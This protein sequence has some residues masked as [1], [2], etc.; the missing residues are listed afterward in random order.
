MRLHSCTS[1]VT[2][3][4]SYPSIPTEKAD[5]FILRQQRPHTNVAFHAVVFKYH[6]HVVYSQSLC[7]SEKA[8]KCQKHHPRR[9]LGYHFNRIATPTFINLHRQSLT[10]SSNH[11][12][13]LA[14]FDH[15]CQIS[16]SISC[17]KEGTHLHLHSNGWQM[18]FL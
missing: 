15:M 11:C 10:S 8:E 5:F 3:I 17:S 13:E 2:R 14:L 9:V 1:T 12:N 16:T 18:G 7:F 4:L 6:H